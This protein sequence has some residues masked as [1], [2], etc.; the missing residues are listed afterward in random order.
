MPEFNA[1]VGACLY[2]AV[3]DDGEKS[4]YR[5]VH[6]I[7]E[8]HMAKI[9]IIGSGNV[10]ANTAFFLAENNVADVTL[11]DVKE[12]LSTGKA[13]DMMEAAPI[14][15][16]L[17]QLNGTDDLN[18]ILDS[19]ILIITAG[20]LRRPGMKREELFSDNIAIID[21]LIDKLTSFPGIVLMVTEPVDSLTTAFIRTSGLPSER[22]MGLGGF[23]DTTRLRYLIA[24]ELS[25]AMENV[26]AMVIGRH[27]DEMLPLPAYCHVSGIPVDTLIGEDRLVEICEEMKS[28]GG[29]IVDLAKRSS[30]YYGPS[31]VI[32]DLADAIIRDTHKIIPV[33]T[34]LSGQYGISEVAMSL[35]A[36][37]GR[38]GIERVMEPVLSEN[39]KSELTRS[40]DSIKSLV[41]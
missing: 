40:A 31:A 7:R 5:V 22:V 38:A 29:M 34:M 20:A 33:S 39:Q 32:S 26:S 6:T 11:Y 18:E 4:Y 12:G 23:L 8:R 15:G 37:I 21:E 14:R 30:A 25:V 16:Y 27:S 41:E 9:G 10:G 13:L 36:V 17:T 28:S 24:K 19:D 3:A 2:S 1:K 35:P